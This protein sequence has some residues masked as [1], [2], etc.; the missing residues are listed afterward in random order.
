MRVQALKKEKGKKMGP[1]S[2]FLCVSYKAEFQ[3]IKQKGICYVRE[4]SS[5]TPRQGAEEAQ[6]VTPRGCDVGAP[7]THH[8]WPLL[9]DTQT[10]PHERK[11]G[12]F[13]LPGSAL[14]IRC[15]QPYGVFIS[16]QACEKI[17]SASTFLKLV[18]DFRDFLVMPHYSIEKIPKIIMMKFYAFAGPDSPEV[19]YIVDMRIMKHF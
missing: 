3:L 16:V 9:G 14:K 17:L 19:R 4:Q 7:F 18:S 12:F 10:N 1:G 15:Q 8:F 2:S 5:G 11:K 13:F 6:Q